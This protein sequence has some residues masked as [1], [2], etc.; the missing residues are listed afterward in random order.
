[1]Y[2]LA[3][4]SV[5]SVAFSPDMFEFLNRALHST[6]PDSGASSWPG[7]LDSA[8][9]RAL[10]DDAVPIPDSPHVVRLRNSRGGPYYLV[11]DSAEP[12]PEGMWADLD[13]DAVTAEATRINERPLEERETTKLPSDIRDRLE[14]GGP[15]ALRLL[16]L[17]D[18]DAPS[19]GDSARSLR[20]DTSL[21]PG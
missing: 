16:E 15:A 1:V 21:E 12:L 9:Q 19:P 20:V 14:G 11:P 10:A 17:L 3:V 2:E 4:D 8:E 5:D 7:E 13:A 6:T 18:R